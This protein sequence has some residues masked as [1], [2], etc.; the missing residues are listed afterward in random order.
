MQSQCNSI[1]QS[2]YYHITQD[3]N[4]MYPKFVY[5]HIFNTLRIFL[6]TFDKFSQF[7]LLSRTV[8]LHF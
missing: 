4:T 5:L 7:Y 2:I 1:H 8:Y 3:S 6:Q